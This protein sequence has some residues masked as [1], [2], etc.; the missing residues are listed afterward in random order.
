MATKST[1]PNDDTTN[2]E[3]EPEPFVHPEGDDGVNGIEG[4]IIYP[5]REVD[6]ERAA[7]FAAGKVDT[8]NPDEDK[9][10]SGWQNPADRPEEELTD[11]DDDDDE[12][13]AQKRE[14][15]VQRSAEIK[16]EASKSTSKK[17]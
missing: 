6:A 10:E 13:R 17:S 2:E 1:N 15:S 7:A 3:T 9:D 4:Q 5:D 11:D 8:L 16:R 12:V 14:K